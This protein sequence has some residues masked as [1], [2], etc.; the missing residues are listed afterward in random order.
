MKYKAELRSFA[1]YYKLAPALYLSKF[2]W[3]WTNSL[4]R[5]IAGKHQ[6]SRNKV[7]QTLIRTHG[8]DVYKTERNGKKFEI[9]IFKIKNRSQSVVV[10]P[11]LFPN[12]VQFGGKTELLD[13]MSADSCEYCG[14]VEK[15]KNSSR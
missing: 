13:R 10:S 8:R 14:S 1:N 4:A 5:T 12:T 7:Y 6:T 3:V 11:D 2:E 9:K 15:L